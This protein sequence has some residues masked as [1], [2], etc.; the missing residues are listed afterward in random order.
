MRGQANWAFLKTLVFAVVAPG[1]VTVVVPYLLL[2]SRAEFEI[3]IARL[4]GVVPIVLGAIGLLWCAWDFVFTGCGTPAPIDPP[5]VLVVKRLYR[6]VRNPMYVTVALILGGEAILFQSLR[7]A[8]YALLA[9]SACHLFVVFYEE[10]TLKKKFG[11]AYEAY[12][13]AVP[14]WIPR[15]AAHREED[16]HPNQRK[17]SG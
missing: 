4:V 13:R 3:G 9:W 5:K 1:T 2:T 16:Q 7:L 11:T 14:R 6:F 17:N 12:C 10:P 15:F 8:A